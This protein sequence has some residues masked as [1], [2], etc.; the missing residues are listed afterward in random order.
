MKMKE[1]KFDVGDVLGLVL[2]DTG[3]IKLHV[4]EVHAQKC[5][6]GIEQIRYSCRVHVTRF[7]GDAA[8]V[9]SHLFDFNEMEVRKPIISET[10][11]ST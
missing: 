2:D 10:S 7:K 1:P 4:I 6:A 3:K 9:T 5:P 8:T 11:P